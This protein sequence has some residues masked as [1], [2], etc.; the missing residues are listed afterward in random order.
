[1]LFA[2]KQSIPI[3]AYYV[4]L[5]AFRE[6]YRLMIKIMIV[7]KAVVCKDRVI[8][9]DPQALDNAVHSHHVNQHT[10]YFARVLENNQFGTPCS[11]K[12][13]QMPTIN[14]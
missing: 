5:V 12:M 3:P 14:K 13:F 4:Q 9:W 2:K 6:R 7:Q 1:M 11:L 8:A 10:M